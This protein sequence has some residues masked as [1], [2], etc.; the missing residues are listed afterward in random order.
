MA[1][2]QRNENEDTAMYSHTF[3]DSGTGGQDCQPELEYIED[4]D[5]EPPYDDGFDDLNE[6]NEDEET[7]TDEEKEEE[8]RRKY[9][10]AAEVGDFAGTVAGVA[11]ILIL[12]AFLI[13]MLQVLSTDLA[14]TFFLWQTKF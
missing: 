8:Q 5:E 12:V 11:A 6:F 1:Y 7:L 9:R 3:R 10:F 13:N 14:H 2:F 4:Y